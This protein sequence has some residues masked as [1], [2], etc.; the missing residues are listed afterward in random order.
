MKALSISEVSLIDD[1]YQPCYAGTSIDLRAYAE[2]EEDA[3]FTELRFDADV[4]EK[5][6][7]PDAPDFSAF[8]SR[9]AKAEMRG[10]E[11]RAEMLSDPP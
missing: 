1:R 9:I 7:E 10:Y 4:H 3:D 11:M 8:E 2:G 5:S 6:P